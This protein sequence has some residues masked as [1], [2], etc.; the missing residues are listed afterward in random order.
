MA[1]KFYLT[2]SL[3]GIE[4]QYHDFLKEN[5][6]QNQVGGKILNVTEASIFMAL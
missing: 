1:S 5:K 4:M 6:R 2:A 3:L